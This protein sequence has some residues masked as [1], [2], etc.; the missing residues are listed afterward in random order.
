MSQVNFTQRQI[1]LLSELKANYES[2][3]KE[4]QENYRLSGYRFWLTEASVPYVDCNGYEYSEP[5]FMQ[6]DELR[7]LAEICEYITFVENTQIAMY[8]NEH[9]LVHP[10]ILEFE[11]P[12]QI[13]LDTQ[14]LADLFGLLAMQGLA[15]ESFRQMFFDTETGVITLVCSDYTLMSGQD[16]EVQFAM[17]RGCEADASS[18]EFE[19]YINR[20]AL[21]PTASK[22][23]HKLN[24]ERLGV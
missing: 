6:F 14:N 13:E 18:Q 12:S 2:F 4:R 19:E 20:M 7:E 11:A 23:I 15:D 17:R 10:S 8:A 9:V 3:A 1:Q 16:S 5:Q 22:I 21:V 24:Y